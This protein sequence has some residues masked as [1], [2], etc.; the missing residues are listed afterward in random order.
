[1]NKSIVKNEKTAL[2]ALEF[3]ETS[4]IKNGYPPTVREIGKSVGLSSPSSAMAIVKTLADRGWITMRDRLPRTIVT[5]EL[6]K[7]EI[8]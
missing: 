7:R 8:R 1:M 5:T 4:Y 6:G 2:K 3:I